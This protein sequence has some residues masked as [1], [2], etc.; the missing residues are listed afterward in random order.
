MRINQQF[1]DKHTNSTLEVDWVLKQEIEKDICLLYH[2]TAEYS[3]LMDDLCYGSVFALPYWDFLD[4]QGVDD[5]ERI[6][7]RDGCLVMILAM[8]M[9][10]IGGSGAYIHDKI[11]VCRRQVSH[12]VP[13]DEKAAKLIKTVNLALESAKVIANEGTEELTDLSLWVYR[14]YVQ[15]YF[16]KIVHDFDNDPYYGNS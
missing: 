4:F 15:G 11:E 12:L 10:C 13:E 9:E 14:E 2:Q 5:N 16:R 6:F 7:I 1:Q 3:W 8:C